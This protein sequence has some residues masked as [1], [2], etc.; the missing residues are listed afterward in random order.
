MTIM[1]TFE[2]WWEEGA[3]QSGDTSLYDAFKSGWSIGFRECQTAN[4]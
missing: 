3:N 1:T 2:K 4:E